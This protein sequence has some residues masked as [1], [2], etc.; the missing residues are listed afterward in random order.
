VHKYDLKR[1][2]ILAG[3]P[4]FLGGFGSIFAGWMTPRVQHL[5]GGV[6]LTR[7]L[8]GVLG[9]TGAACCMMTATLLHEPILA[10][11]AIASASFFNDITMPASWTTCMDVGDKYVGTVAGTMNMMGN[12]GGFVSPIV[13]GYIVGRT[14]DWNLTFYVTAALYIFGGICWWFIDPITPLEQQVKD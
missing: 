5:F 8:T 6:S 3:L 9:F 10:V 12:F 4:L 11:I 1:S 2:A 7:R 14:G 13:L